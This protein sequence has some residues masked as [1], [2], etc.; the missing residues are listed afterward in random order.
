MAG[1]NVIGDAQIIS[2]TAEYS[3]SDPNPFVHFAT[4]ALIP[5]PL[6]FRCDVAGSAGDAGEQS[7]PASVSSVFLQ[8]TAKIAKPKSYFFYP[9][10]PGTARQGRCG[11]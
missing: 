6:R 3:Q 7:A 9:Y 5:V 4:L 10:F 1:R 11:A 2:F 8:S